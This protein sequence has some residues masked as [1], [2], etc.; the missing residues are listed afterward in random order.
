M[1]IVRL[2]GLAETNMASEQDQLLMRLLIPVAKLY[3]GKQVRNS[4]FEPG[5]GL[6]GTV[7]TVALESG[8]TNTANVKGSDGRGYRHQ[9]LAAG[10]AAVT[11]LRLGWRWWV[12]D[13]SLC[14]QGHRSA[15]RSG[16][17]E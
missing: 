2:L 9:A 11:A 12:G 6:R 14:S 8:V 4:R 5:V 17:M 3:T 15:V 16:R 1:E 10:P 13:L 7:A